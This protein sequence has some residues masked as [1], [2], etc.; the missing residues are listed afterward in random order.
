MGNA[1][2]ISN[3]IQSKFTNYAGLLLYD[4]T[5]RL[6][7]F[8]QPLK[9]TMNNVQLNAKHVIATATLRN[10]MTSSLPLRI[11][12]MVTS[13]VEKMKTRPPHARKKLPSASVGGRD[14]RIDCGGPSH[15][16]KYVRHLRTEKPTSRLPHNACI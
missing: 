4:R 12:A 7:D 3:R 11:A 6:R 1:R 16:K 15:K 13:S 2:A 10:I 8:S 9:P 14:G 5:G